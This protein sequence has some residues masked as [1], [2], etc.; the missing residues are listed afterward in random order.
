MATFNQWTFIGRLG[1]DPELTVTGDGKPI[2][3][4]SLA[5]DCKFLN[6]V[7]LTQLR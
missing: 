1:K 5:V 7:A 4:F 2:T 6:C 3:K